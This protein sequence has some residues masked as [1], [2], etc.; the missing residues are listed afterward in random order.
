MFEPRLLQFFLGILP[1]LLFELDLAA[2]L[3][4]SRFIN[5]VFERDLMFDTGQI[6]DNRAA[7]SDQKTGED[8][9]D[10]P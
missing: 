1:G 2:Q 5:K 7:E 4:G 8:E 9:S 6:L 3:L 10:Q